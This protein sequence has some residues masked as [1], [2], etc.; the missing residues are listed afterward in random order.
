MLTVTTHYIRD[1]IKAEHL[2]ALN[3]EV[4][5]ETPHIITIG[6]GYHT[7]VLDCYDK[8]YS[9]RLTISDGTETLIIKSYG[10]YKV[11]GI[12]LP[13][14]IKTI[15]LIG[16]SFYTSESE[17]IFEQI[18]RDGDCNLIIPHLPVNLIIDNCSLNVTDEEYYNFNSYKSLSI[19]NLDWHTFSSDEYPASSRGLF[20][21]EIVP[22][23]LSMAPTATF[24]EDTLEL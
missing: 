1:L 24:E 18:N 21:N 8:I 15:K 19:N 9:Y 5:D 2:I 7:V 17:T 20:Y 4:N 6:N 12:I 16:I 22:Y 14:T 13:S 3:P 23:L 10:G 11:G